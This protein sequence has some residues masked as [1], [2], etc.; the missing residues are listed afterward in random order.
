[1]LLS[2][3]SERPEIAQDITV[4]VEGNECLTRAFEQ[5]VLKETLDGD[6]QYEC[7]ACAKKVDATKVRAR[8]RAP[9]AAA[10]AVRGSRQGHRGHRT[11]P[12][13]AT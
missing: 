7:E 2:C 13:R 1:M 10:A 4:E 5:L 12:R 3:V 9:L 11:S 8:P 6:N